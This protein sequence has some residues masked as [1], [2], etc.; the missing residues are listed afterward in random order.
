MDFAFSGALLDEP[1]GQGEYTETLLRLPSFGTYYEPLRPAV[2]GAGSRASFGLREGSVLYWVGHQAATFLPQ[3]DD[4]YARITE[5]VPDSQMVFIETRGE[6]AISAFRERMDRAF[7]ARGLSSS[8]R[9]VFLPPLQPQDFA[10]VT[11]LMDVGL[12]TIGWSGCNTTLETLM[13]DVPVVTLP[14]SR[15]RTRHAFAFLTMMGVT[16]TI[17]RSSDD[18]VEIAARLGNDPAWR[19]TISEKVASTKARCYRDRECV[20]ALEEFFERCVAERSL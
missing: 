4:I 10:A 17:A 8:S 20:S 1:E 19:R 12:D 3:H 2:G 15:T 5:R 9:C 18:F 7:S 13:Y 11:R 6:S 16:E 14:G